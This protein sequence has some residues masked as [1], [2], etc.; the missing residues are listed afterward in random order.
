MKPNKIESYY[1]ELGGR[2][3]LTETKPYNPGDDIRVPLIFGAI[4]IPL[5]II[6]LLVVT[7]IKN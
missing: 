2:P 5:T 7:M 6:F 1:K 4:F 3:K